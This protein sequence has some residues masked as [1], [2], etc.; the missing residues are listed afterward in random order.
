[1]SNLIWRKKQKLIIAARNTELFVQTVYYKP[2]PHS[3]RNLLLMLLMVGVAFASIAIMTTTVAI[4]LILVVVALPLIFSFV[5]GKQ[6]F[7]VNAVYDVPLIFEPNAVQVEDEYFNI[8]D[9]E[10]ISVYVHSFYGFRYSPSRLAGRSRSFD[11]IFSGNAR[12]EFGDKNEIH[13]SVYGK[14]YECRFLLGSGRAW[15]ALYQVLE[16]WKMQ[17]KSIILKEEYPF[18]FVENEIAAYSS[19]ES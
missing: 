2:N 19:V 8:K 13:F 15:Y 9:I 5:T 16:A 7:S 14:Q 12:S 6:W 18:S 1:M 4:V 10:D 17:G 11:D 3:F